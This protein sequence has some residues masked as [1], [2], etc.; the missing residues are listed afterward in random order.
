[1]GHDMLTK[2]TT[3]PGLTPFN[4]KGQA[5]VIKL[6]SSLKDANEA[7]AEVAGHIAELCETTTC[8]QFSTVLQ[9]AIRPLVEL[10]VL[11][12]LC[13]SAHNT[14]DVEKLTLGETFKQS[15]INSLLPMPYHP[16]LSKVDYKH[17]TRCQST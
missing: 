7:L 16:K 3:I 12:N 14:F 2:M 9:L 4:N 5:M 15:Y 17:A 13:S 8:D 10:Q 1:M 6:F 11:G